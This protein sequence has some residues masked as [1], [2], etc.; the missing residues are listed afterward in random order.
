MPFFER[1]RLQSMTLKSM[2]AR[3]FW[4]KGGLERRPRSWDS[5]GDGAA[6]EHLE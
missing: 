2:L 5:T 1:M 3:E 6:E 4:Q